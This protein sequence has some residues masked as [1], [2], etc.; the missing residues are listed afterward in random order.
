[1]TEAR[2]YWARFEVRGRDLLRFD[3]RVY[4]EPVERPRA[5]DRPLGCIIGKNPGSAVPSQVSGELQAIALQG[6]HFLPS[7]RAIVTR[8]AARAGVDPP[9]GAFVQVLNLF[10]LCNRDLRAAKAALVGADADR[11]CASERRRFPWCWYAWGGPDPLLDPL[12]VRFLGRRKGPAFYLEGG[13]HEIVATMP[14]ISDKARHTQGM[15]QEPVVAHLARL[16]G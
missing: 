14:G 15:P 10:Y 13:A 5:A 16:M 9:A 6:D 8:G 12:K 3:T 2:A 1:V 11:V 7:V 4:L